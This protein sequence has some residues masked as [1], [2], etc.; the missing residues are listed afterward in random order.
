MSQ[1]KNDEGL[2]VRLFPMLSGQDD[3]AWSRHMHPISVWSRIL[4]GL[5]LLAV[6]GWSRVVIGAWWI[7]ALLAVVVFLWLNPRMTPRPKSL[8]NWSARA[9]RGERHWVVS[10]RQSL[11]RHHRFVPGLLVGLSAAG[12]LVLVFGVLFLNLRLTM[13]GIAAGLGFKLWFLDRMAWL[14]RDLCRAG[15]GK[16]AALSFPTSGLAF[17]GTGQ[18]NDDHSG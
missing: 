18:R 16:V 9:V 14:D 13:L 4:L 17:S 7:A 6:A 15:N 11:P 3:E 2:L 5:P 10:R 8:D 1:P 12:H